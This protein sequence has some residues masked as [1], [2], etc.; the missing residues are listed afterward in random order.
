MANDKDSKT[1][2]VDWLFDLWASKHF[3]NNMDCYINFVED[4]TQCNYIVLNGREKYKVKGK[5]NVLLQ[6]RSKKLMIK[7]VYYVP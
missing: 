2:K 6:L 5:G 1:S 7:D 4:K 3:T